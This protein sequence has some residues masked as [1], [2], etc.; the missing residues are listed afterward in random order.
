MAALVRRPSA[1]LP[2]VLSMI[3][4]AMVLGYAALFGTAQSPQPH[5]E[6]TPARVFQLL[7]TATAVAIAIF[8]VRWL[9]RAP[10]ESATIIVL[11]LL[12]AALPVVA[13]LLL[14]S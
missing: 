9:P 13:I 5:D 12:I 2:I 11:Q 10:R 8:A 1:W 7:M 6:G 14:E 4:L 3:A